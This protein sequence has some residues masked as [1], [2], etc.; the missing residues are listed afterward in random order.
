M[1]DVA[2]RAGV[3]KATIYRRWPSRAAL[4]LDAWKHVVAPVDLPDTGSVRSDVTALLDTVIDTVTTGRSIDLL[5]HVVAA[6][7]TD[8][9]LAAVFADYV[10]DRRRSLRSVLERARARGELRATADL[11]ALHDALAGPIFYRMLLS[12]APVDHV[13]L[14]HSIDV[15]LS[16][17]LTPGAPAASAPAAAG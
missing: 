5:P 12:H 7:R 6:A 11:D 1:D 4:V 2:A 16:G 14:R 15:V 9:E 13:W 3:G 8:P 10:A 17:N